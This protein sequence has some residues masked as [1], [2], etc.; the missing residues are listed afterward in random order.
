MADFRLGVDVGGTFTDIV[1]IKSD[2]TIYPKKV[3]STPQ[4][5]SVAIKQGV[6]E[7]FAERGISAGQVKE[8][9]H[10]A[11]VATNAII[12]RSGATTALITTK[13]FRDVL[14]IRRM[15]MPRL[16]DLNWEKPAPLVPRHLRFE[17]AARMNP[18]GE[19]VD[20]L[21]EETVLNV[22]QRLLKEG[23]QSV[24]VCFLHAY[25]NGAHEQRVRDLINELAP[26]ISVS[27]SSEVLPESQEYERT[28]TTVINAYVQP[29]VSRYFLHMERDLKAMGM[30]IPIMVM[31]S[32][33]GMMPSALAKERPVHII[34]SGPAAGVTGSHALASKMNISDVMTLDMGG[35]T[36][37]AALIENGEIS[38][39]PE[40]EVG[41]TIS[42]GHR[43]I[44]G[45]GYLLRV[46]SVDLAEVGAGGGSVAWVDD[47]GV[48]KVGPD[49]TG[50]MPGPA[51]YN[52]G[53]EEA[54]ITDAN[55]YMGLTN[56]NWLAGGT[57]EIHPELA[58]EAIQERIATPLGLD[59]ASAA[60]G[61]RTVANSSLNRAL[62]AVSTERGRDPRRFTL[63]AFGGMGPVHA[64]DLAADLAIGKIIV[65]PLPGLFSSV[66]LLCAD[67]EHHLIRTH[68]VYATDLDFGRANQTVRVLLKEASSTLEQEG[69]DSAHRS[70]QLSADIRY[71]GQDYALTIP[72][73]S[74]CLSTQFLNSLVEE[75]HQEHQKTYGY[76]SDQ[77]E[78]QITAFRCLGRG[79]SNLHRMPPTLQIADV[80]GWTVPV[81]D[82]KAYFGPGLGWITVPVVSRDALSIEPSP[83]PMIVEEDNS[84]TVVPPHWKAS[85]DEW[86]NIVLEAL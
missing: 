34:E 29:G 16:Y 18:L 80:A 25:A 17:V 37:K 52:Q 19:Q 70:V 85:I 14:E 78:V 69:F 74:D 61:I 7:T 43:L 8:Y 46:P 73:R 84:L 22:I 49:S 71:A 38:R 39:S 1:V 33:G 59:L 63:F 51:C 57:L 5:F 55:V 13:G 81:E 26:N 58:E 64:A 53:G 44:K 9:T 23:V 42:I 10:G 48:L 4:N 31:Q 77:E 27:I 75:F 66:G 65:P 24:A 15:R 32:N 36:A 83:G 67:V 20:P 79:I 3:L 86:S 50:A 76:R 35:T 12:T 56:P 68:Y 72:M 6:R 21:D 28:S 2:G 60:W 82:R 47:S 41:G 62:R 54:T 30:S 45:S 11:T 40:Y